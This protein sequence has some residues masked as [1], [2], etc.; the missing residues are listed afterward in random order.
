MTS[1]D[2]SYD[3]IVVGAGPAGSTAARELSQTGCKVLLI[4]KNKFPRNKICG[5]LIPVKALRELDFSIPDYYIKNKIYKLSV[6]NH[7]MKNTTYENKGLMGITTLREEFD[8]HLLNRAIAKGTIFHEETAFKKLSNE[9]SYLKIYTDRGVFFCNYLVGCDGTFSR[10]RKYVDGKTGSQLFKKG[11]TLSTKIPLSEDWKENEF[12][13]YQIPVLYTMGW[14][15]PCDDHINVGIGGPWFNK[16]KILKYFTRFLEDIG[17]DRNNF[18]IHGG[19]LPAGGLYRRICNDKV[20]LAGDA[21]GFVDPM[22]GEG[23]YYA[24][25]SGKIAAS[26]ILKNEI[27]HYEDLCYAEF[28]ATLRKSLIRNLIGIN[29][30][31]SRNTSLRERLSISFSET[32]H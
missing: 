18:T 3:V 31:Y 16:N 32:M 2:N 15:I 26:Q 28:N 19:F 27:L 6:Y 22:T 21:G 10:V 11:F 13:V 14:G 25:R 9:N 23:I 4:D 1:S 24:I 17:N 30:L 5:G 29:K 7:K 12:R 8:H 20:I